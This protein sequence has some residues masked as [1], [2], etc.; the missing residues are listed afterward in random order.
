[1]GGVLGNTRRRVGITHEFDAHPLG[2]NG[3]GPLNSGNPGRLD[4][5]YVRYGG[6]QDC[7][8]SPQLIGVSRL[9]VAWLESS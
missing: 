9:R 7:L 1:M 4:K 5:G 2:G 8:S 6:Q 3:V